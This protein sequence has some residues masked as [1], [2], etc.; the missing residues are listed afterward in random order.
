MIPIDHR[1]TENYSIYGVRHAQARNVIERLFRVAKKKFRL[2]DQGPKHD[3]CT[4]AK[5]ISAM[6]VIFNF[7]RIHDPADPEMMSGQAEAAIIERNYA[8]TQS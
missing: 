2:L 8:C 7:V 5:F 3:E 1:I 6:G 4:Q